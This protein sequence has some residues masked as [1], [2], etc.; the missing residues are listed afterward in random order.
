MNVLLVAVILL[1][2]FPVV[3]LHELGHLIIAAWLGARGFTSPLANQ[4]AGSHGLYR[5]QG[6]PF[7]FTWTGGFSSPHPT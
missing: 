3:L 5:Y 6:S 7:A 1:A 2:F 4:I